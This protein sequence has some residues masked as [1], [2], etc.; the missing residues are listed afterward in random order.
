MIYWINFWRL[1]VMMKRKIQ[2]E[3]F[4]D[5]GLAEKKAS[6]YQPGGVESF[7]WYEDG[8]AYSCQIVHI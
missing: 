2:K 4:T 5:W 6:R 7:T 3:L 8:I 1:F